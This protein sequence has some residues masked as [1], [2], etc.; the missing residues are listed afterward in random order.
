MNLL[1]YSQMIKKKNMGSLVAYAYM[2]YVTLVGS[3]GDAFNFVFICYEILIALV[4]NQCE[5]RMNQIER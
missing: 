3:Y 1:L 5:Q 4:M 2:F